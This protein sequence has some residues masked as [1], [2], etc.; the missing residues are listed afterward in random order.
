MSGIGTLPWLLAIAHDRLHPPP[1]PKPDLTNR[2]IL[3][4]GA[5]TG[6]GFE[7][8][9]KFV[10]LNASRVI[11]AVRSLS[12][13]ETARTEIEKRT[14]RKGVVEVWA[15]EMGDYASIKDFVGRVERE[16]ER[17]DVAVLNAGVAKLGFEAGQYGWEGTLQVNTLST[18]LLALLL[19]PKLRASRTADS[20]PVLELV[21]SGNHTQVQINPSAHTAPSPLEVYNSP[22]AYDGLAQYSISKL[23]LQFFQTGL[24]RH[25]G[26]SVQQ[27]GVEV[28]TIC[29]GATKSEL[30][31]GDLP[32]ALRVFQK[33]FYYVLMKP[34]EQGARTYVGGVELKGRGHG[35]FF[36][37]GRVDEPA[38]TLTGPENE[39]LQ[40]KVWEDIL[41]ILRKDVPEVDGVLASVAAATSEEGRSKD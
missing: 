11:L 2:T 8:A 7:A 16:V 23:F 24:V 10:S 41:R 33:V 15:L 27:A 28:V 9:L 5:N 39:K 19:L 29:P 3:I 32:L 37:Y 6:V 14:G 34:T 30:A 25:L 22:T 18:A 20:T 31:R 21:S 4:T 13:G 38:P 36:R 35:G 26:A 12:K 1:D 17:L 40:E